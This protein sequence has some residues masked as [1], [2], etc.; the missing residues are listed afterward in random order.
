MVVQYATKWCGSRCGAELVLLEYNPGTE[1][2]P[3]GKRIGLLFVWGK[4][5]Y[6]GV[7]GIK[8]V[9]KA[10]K[11]AVVP[12]PPLNGSRLGRLRW[13]SAHILG[14]LMRILRRP[15]EVG[16]RKATKT[17]AVGPAVSAPTWTPTTSLVLMTA[18][19]VLSPSGSVEEGQHPTPLLYPSSRAA[20]VL[21]HS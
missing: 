10:N 7:E 5:M 3:E 11:G 1:P 18:K 16:L 17:Q 6:P 4:A 13:L 14:T 21:H 19:G 2:I 9:A 15:T 8:A 20:S 12:P